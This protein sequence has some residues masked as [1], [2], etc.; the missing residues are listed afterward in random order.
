MAFVARRLGFNPAK[1]GARRY[2]VRLM[3]G[4]VAVIFCLGLLNYW[5]YRSQQNAELAHLQATLKRPA[6]FDGTQIQDANLKETDFRSQ[7]SSVQS[8]TTAEAQRLLQ[9]GSET[10]AAVFFDI[11]ET[12]EHKMGTLPGANHVRF[13]DF[14]QSLVPE[15][16]K[17]VL[18]CH[19]G[20]RSSETCEAL[21]AQ[22]IDCS[23]IAGGIEKWIVEGR[24]FSDANVR[25][26][27]DLRAIPEYPNRDTLI[28]T[29]EFEELFATK[30]LQIIDA[31]YPGDFAT[32]HLPSA[33]NIPVRALPTSEL[34]RL[35]A[36]LEPKPTIAACYDRRSCFMSQVLG[37]ELHGRGIEFLGRYTTPWEYFVAPEPKPHVQEWLAAQNRTY[38]QQATDLLATGLIWSHGASHLIFGL[39]ALSLISRILILPVALK[40]E[41]DQMV[42]ARHAEELRTIKTDLRH[43]PARKARA[44]QEFYAEKGMT[45]MRNLL[46]LLFLPLMMI[47]I[48]AA[49]IAGRETA[50]SFLWYENLGAPDA[51][52][53]L[54]LLLASLGTAYLVWIVGKTPRQKLLWAVG[55][56]VS[57]FALVTQFSAAGLIYLC[58]SLALLLVQRSYVTGLMGRW[59]D[60]IGGTMRALRPGRYPAGVW[61]LSASGELTSSGNKALRLAKLRQAGFPVP[62]GVVIQADAINGFER[63]DPSQRKDFAAEIWR[64]IGQ[65]PCAVRSSASDEDG[66]DQSFAG[67]FESVLDVDGRSM[68]AAIA[69]VISSFS[70]ERAGAYRADAP[71]AHAGNI[72]VQEMVASEYAGVLFTQDPSAPGQMIVELVEGCGEDLVSGRKT[73]QSLRFGRFTHSAMDDQSPPIELSEL[74]QLGKRIEALFSCPQDIEWAYADGAFQ[75]VQSRD[76]TAAASS[77]AKETAR[78]REWQVFLIS[79]IVRMPGPS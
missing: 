61:P 18:F 12:G 46:G 33:V 36:R 55:G 57:I 15:G 13:P 79:G 17:V 66:A 20:N 27:S 71:S 52:Y 11:R 19:N 43:D 10:G 72:L 69:E 62:D 48:G 9:A 39:L 58:I 40:S 30:D 5:Q 29:P 59:V 65:K 6:Q 2:P 64:L 41:R 68:E 75:I 63:M 74:L 4:L 7:L 54:P 45:P 34:D 23:F 14:S 51:A 1:A 44:L 16:K 70:S 32:G 67:V 24:P 78:Q 50:T 49:E 76:V 60:Y 38:W 35:I 26:L 28:G 8:V 42:S 56:F 47:G 22:G 73:P 25:T 31:R 53:L 3:V 77:R 37:L 21:A